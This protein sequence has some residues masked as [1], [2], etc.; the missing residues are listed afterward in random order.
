MTHVQQLQNSPGI[1]QPFDVRPGLHLLRRAADSAYRKTPHCSIRGCFAQ[2]SGAQGLGGL[3]PQRG[4]DSPVGEGP[5]G[6]FS[7]LDWPGKGTGVRGPEDGETPLSW[8]EV[9]HAMQTEEGIPR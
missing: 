3:G 4:Q 2:T 1:S 7:G 6:I 5:D 9:I 8:A